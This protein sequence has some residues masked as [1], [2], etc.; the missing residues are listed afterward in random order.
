MPAHPRLEALANDLE[1]S[2]GDAAVVER[3]VYDG[4]RG[5]VVTIRP[6]R[7]D[8][9]TI[10][11]A[12]LDM[13]VILDLPGTGG[14]WELGPSDSDLDLLEAIVRSVIDGRVSEVRGPARSRV[15]V[16]LGDGKSQTTSVGQAPV[17]C[18]PMPFWTRWG[19]KVQHSPYLA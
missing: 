13:E 15:T 17:G 10:W 6:R 11:W 18:L 5:H 4:L 14:R 3:E 8:A 1:R 12:D 2:L 19:R 9:V 7:S 16:T